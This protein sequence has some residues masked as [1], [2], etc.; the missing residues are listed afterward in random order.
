ML[1]NK[2]HTMKYLLN[3][4]ICI[5]VMLFSIMT[6]AH[7]AT[8]EI[9]L[10]QLLILVDEGKYTDALATIETLPSKDKNRLDIRFHRATSLAGIGKNRE[11]IAMFEKLIEEAPQHP[12]FYNNLA[13][14]FVEEGM[15]LKAQ[16]TLELGL[17]SSESYAMLYNNLTVV[18]ETMARRSYAKALRVEREQSPVLS[19]ILSL[20]SLGL[21]TEP[22][23]SVAVSTV[24]SVAVAP[25]DERSESLSR[26][27]KSSLNHWAKS[28]QNKDID[29]YIDSY[30]P[31]FKSRSYSSRQA[32]M[33]G[34][35]ER[36]NRANEIEI[37]ISDMVID[38]LSS[39]RVQVDFVMG[40]RSDRYRDRTKKR[41]VFKRMAGK[42]RIV[43]ELTLEV[44]DS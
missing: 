34:R 16:Q 33:E 13:M 17:R 4:L 10:E 41:V 22:V 21:S 37:S 29:D 6:V 12:E 18:F 11:S 14:V 19:P 32:W 30:S 40:Y 31:N 3:S 28:W 26:A 25:G 1:E 7:A 35:N 9:E 44:L 8:A 23:V 42:W 43:R 20:N 27:I 39:E 15:L 5:W 36:I 38:A 2:V 24:P